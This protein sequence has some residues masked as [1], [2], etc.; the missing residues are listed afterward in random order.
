MNELERVIAQYRDSEL[1]A[2]VDFNVYNELMM[3]YSSSAME[4]ST[5][6]FHETEILILEG[7]T[8]DGKPHDHSQMVTDHHKALVMIKEWAK[9]KELVLDRNLIQQ[10]GAAVMAST[11]GAVNTALGTYNTAK[12]DYRLANVRAAGGHYYINYD[13]VGPRM[14]E[15]LQN[16]NENLPLVS[17]LGDVF[18]LSCYLHL[19][20]LTIHPFGDGNGRAARLLQN[21]LLLHKNMP[22]LVIKPEKKG[23]YIEA[24]KESRKS[25]DIT[26][27]MDFTKEQY[28]HYWKKELSSFKR[29]DQGRGMMFFFQL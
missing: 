3:D 8:P 2:T 6:T 20:F 14:E 1:H 24:I 15:L 13:K 12:G 25:D 17:K 16:V 9:S 7:R 5:L 21:L 29:R 28:L 27:F 22:L 19:N 23:P 4:G 26:A 10:V 11:G 18:R